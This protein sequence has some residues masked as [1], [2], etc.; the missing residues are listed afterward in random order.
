[1]YIY[2]TVSRNITSSA[3]VMAFLRQIV[4]SVLATPEALLMWKQPQ[5]WLKLDARDTD[6]CLVQKMRANGACTKNQYGY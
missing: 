5:Y 2:R 6:R 3:P 4:T 1:M